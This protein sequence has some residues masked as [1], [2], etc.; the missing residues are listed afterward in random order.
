MEFSEGDIRLSALQTIVALNAIPA[1]SVGITVA[2]QNCQV[3]VYQKTTGLY[4]DLLVDSV[5]V[6]AGVRC[7]NGTGMVL[8]AYLGFVGDFMFIDTQGLA[9]PNYTG[10]GSRFLLVY[11]GDSL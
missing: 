6:V 11:V 1:Q 7:R 5:H 8:D 4:F 3:V 2:K 9:D 10:L